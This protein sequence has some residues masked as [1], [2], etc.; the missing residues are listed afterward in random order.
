MRAMGSDRFRALLQDLAD[1]DR[2]LLECRIVD[3]WH[4]GDITAHLGVPRDVLT[5]RVPA[6]KRLEAEGEGVRSMRLRRRRMGRGTRTALL[7][8][9]SVP[10][11]RRSNAT[12]RTATVSPGQVAGGGAVE[13]GEA[14]DSGCG[15]RGAG[16]RDSGAIRRH[17]TRHLPQPV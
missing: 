14:K 3:G 17:R 4:Y 10:E 12:T 16:D 7:R 11:R 2:I 5:D 1:D 15:E 13:L 8:Q 6:A 9:R